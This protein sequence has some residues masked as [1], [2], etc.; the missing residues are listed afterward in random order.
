MPNLG[1]IVSNVNAELVPATNIDT[2]IK[3]WAQKGQGKFLTEAMTNH[4]HQFTWLRQT[5]LQLTL[6]AGVEEYA[7]SPF[8]DMAKLKYFTER[9]TDRRIDLYTL[10][11]MRESIPD[12]SDSSGVPEYAYFAGYSPVQKQPSSASQLEFVSTLSDT[13]VFRIEGLN[14][15]GTAMIGEELTLTGAV[16]VTTTNTYSKILSLGAN[17]FSTGTVTITSNS[18]GVT[19]AVISPRM[20][21][22]KFPKIG[23]YPIPESSG[24]LYYDGNFDLPPLVNNNDFS[25]IPDRYQDAIEE[26]CLFRGYRHKKDFQMAAMSM[27]NFKDIVDQAVKDDKGPARELIMESRCSRG[28]LSEGSLPGNFPRSY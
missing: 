20:R 18:G 25:L 26:Y 1:E 23:V 3:R 2:L 8:L 9:T 17:G 13:T 7:L 28:F 19:N 14:A 6:E 15:A 5:N 12:P 27:A 10:D 16:P 24:T 21:Q 22:P 11:E 4:R